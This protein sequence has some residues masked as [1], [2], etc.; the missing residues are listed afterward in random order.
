MYFI[1]VDTVLHASH[2]IRLPD[3][4]LEPIHQHDWPICIQVAAAELD[5]IE[6]V[7]DFH[8]LHDIVKSLLAPWQ[9]RC[10]NHCAPF[11][12]EM[13]KISINPTAERVAEQIATQLQDKLP[14]PAFLS[15]VSVGEASG[16]RALWRAL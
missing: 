4:S 10:L 6:T 9:N 5:E 8:V 7:M 16:C 15:E 1:E 13:G 12:D 2:A 11:G 3:G 14:H